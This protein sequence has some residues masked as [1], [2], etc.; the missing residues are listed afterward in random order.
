MNIFVLDRDPQ[1][2]A[3]YH[4]DKHVVKM[5][6]ETAQILCA[7]FPKGDAPYK[8]THYNHPCSIWARESL[9][10]FNWLIELGYHLGEEYTARYGK[11]HKSIAVIE[12]CDDHI[13]SLN[14]PQMEMTE[15]ALAMPDYCKTSD[16][17][18]SYR[19]YY[20]EEKKE[21]CSWKNGSPDWLKNYS[22]ARD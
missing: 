12:W 11:T 15:F 8:Q 21:I 7:A 2:A 9:A 6:L 1:K 16:A 20:I 4:C 10:N 3:Q 22:Y 13:P 19:K 17:V 18:E 14:F 5:I